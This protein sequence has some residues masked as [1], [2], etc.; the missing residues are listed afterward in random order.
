MERNELQV[1]LNEP[2]TVWIGTRQ[3]PIEV[4][5]KEPTNAELGKYLSL[6]NLG[7]KRLVSDNIPLINAAVQGKDV[8]NIPF[9]ASAI[10]GAFTSLTAQIVGKD[11]EFVLN[12]MSAAQ[13]VA[14]LKAFGDVMGWEFIKETF[15]Q[16]MRT[17][18][19][20][21]PKKE[22]GAQPSWLG[23]SSSTLSGPTHQ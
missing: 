17:V 23:K 1:F 20:L 21:A 11:E 19:T 22:N 8:S 12:R 4:Q 16:A 13:Q 15:S 10:S 9:D 2:I 3:E 6:V 5:V 18:G 14:I 7:L